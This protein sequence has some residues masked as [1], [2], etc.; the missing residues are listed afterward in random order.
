MN[1]TLSINIFLTCVSLFLT[2]GLL[3]RQSF[4]YLAANQHVSRVY[5]R[6][7]FVQSSNYYMQQLRYHKNEFDQLNSSINKDAYTLN[8]MAAHLEKMSEIYFYFGGDDFNNAGNKLLSYS[9]QLRQQAVRLEKP[10]D[11]PTKA[12]PGSNKANADAWKH[13]NGA[14][15]GPGS[16]PSVMQELMP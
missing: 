5:G 8:S 14:H 1:R 10:A 16:V 3:T 15:S 7:H 6:I 2:E 13:Y 4:A 9:N 12:T 11:M